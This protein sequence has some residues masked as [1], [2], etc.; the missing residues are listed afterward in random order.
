MLVTNCALVWLPKLLCCNHSR[1]RKSRIRFFPDV[2]VLPFS[3]ACQ[4][5]EK[6]FARTLHKQVRNPSRKGARR[7]LEGRVGWL[8]DMWLFRIAEVLTWLTNGSSK[9]KMF[10]QIK[11]GESSLHKS[12][13]ES[14]GKRNQLFWIFNDVAIDLQDQF[15][16]CAVFQFVIGVG[17]SGRLVKFH[18]AEHFFNYILLVRNP[19]D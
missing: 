4:E 8:L 1:R 3:R 17:L 2:C 7:S 16:L 5:A 14:F 15:C 13:W 6:K 9:A 12:T 19:R 11:A 18:L 10:Y